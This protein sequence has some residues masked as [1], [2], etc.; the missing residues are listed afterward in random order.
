[1]MLLEQ[2][3]RASAKL[4]KDNTMHAAICEIVTEVLTGGLGD[5]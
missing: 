2:W 5:N 3:V 1:M 4:D